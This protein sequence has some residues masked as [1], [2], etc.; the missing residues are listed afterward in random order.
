MCPIEPAT[1][2]DGH[3]GSHRDGHSDDELTEELAGLDALEV[4]V[5]PSPGRAT[6]AWAAAWP[7]L[8]AAL[9]ALVAWQLI[10]W[11]GWRSTDVLPGPGPVFET[12]WDDLWSGDL[13]LATALTL[14]RA[15]LGFALGIAIGTP[16]GIAVARVRV[17]RTAV[18]SVVTS[19]QTMPSTAWFPFAILLFSQSETAIMFV[20]VLGAAPA[21]A[22]GLVAGI[23]QIPPNLLRAGRVLGARGWTALRYVVLPAAYPQY[24]AGL[25]QGWAFAWRS[26]IAGELIVQVAGSE[27]IGVRLQ[28][29][30]RSD[31]ATALLATMVVILV[32]GIAVDSLGFGTLERRIRRRYGLATS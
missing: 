16:I 6:R 5:P 13:I 26:L 4:A 9:V 11:S 8:A 24:V 7:K 18:G 1:S 30:Q 27:S 23:D 29:A 14:R 19:L 12:L 32:I 22:N 17:V 15:V 3:S 21:V 2:V 20:V 28:D 10:V 31:D 25:K